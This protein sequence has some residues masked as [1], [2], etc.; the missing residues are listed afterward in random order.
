MSGLLDQALGP[1]LGAEPQRNTQVWG[2]IIISP[3]LCCPPK[4]RTLEGM[5]RG[6]RGSLEL[7]ESRQGSGNDEAL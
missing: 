3:L 2:R 4:G 7:R 6:M 5:D 1:S